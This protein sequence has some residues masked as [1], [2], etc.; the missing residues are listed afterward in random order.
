MVSRAHQGVTAL[1]A[2]ESH[3]PTA[4][5]WRERWLDWRN[6]RYM[7]KTFQLAAQENIFTR[8]LVRRRS[9]ALFDL[10]G[11]FVYSQVLLAFVRLRLHQVLAEG[12][13]CLEELSALTHIPVASM[14]RLMQA[15]VALRLAEPRGA[16]RFGIGVLAAPLVENPGICAM[17]EHHAVLYRD[18]TDPIALLRQDD[19]DTEMARYWPYAGHRASSKAGSL[20]TADV[21]TYSELMAASQPLVAEQVLSAYPIEKHSLVLDVGG[22]A[23][24]FI[25]AAA[26]KAPRTNFMLFDLPAVGQLARARLA[27]HLVLDRVQVFGG[28]FFADPLPAGADLITLVRV[29]FDHPDERALAILKAVR[30]AL[31][32]GQTVLIAEP[33]QKDDASE[34]VGSA[35]FNMYLLAM[36]HGELRTPAQFAHLLGQ[37]GFGPLNRHPSPSPLQTEVFSAKAI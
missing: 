37:S 10:L 30:A 29:L 3:R 6:R 12:P 13:R 16:E 24:N 28:S 22:G 9:K 2:A 17:V 4:S 36:G 25:V 31:K 32:P 19:R 11:G 34:A 21:A 23:G 18:L 35:Y 8:W 27:E 7:S 26:R 33:V 20:D 15:A 14:R 1:A 5:S